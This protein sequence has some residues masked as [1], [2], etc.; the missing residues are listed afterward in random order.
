[1]LVAFLLHF[2]GVI[3]PANS[4]QLG[5]AFYQITYGQEEAICQNLL[6]KLNKTKEIPVCDAINFDLQDTTAPQWE[7]LDI[8]KSL[9]LV[10]LIESD[11]NYEFFKKNNIHR[12]SPDDDDIWLNQLKKR[13]NS[14][15]NPPKLYR[16][17]I[18]LT[19]KNE[20]KWL[21]AYKMDHKKCNPAK[22]ASWAKKNDGMDF[23][24]NAKYGSYEYV[25]GRGRIIFIKDDPYIVDSYLTS[26]THY[27]EWVMT[28]YKITDGPPGS[29]L[30]CY[31]AA[32]KT[33]S[34]PPGQR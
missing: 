12:Y 18:G 32:N 33:F 31:I 3:N 10:K 23:Y 20:I 5:D 26:R 11:E 17:N 8:L 22:F 7:E 28:I 2:Y 1:M 4:Q 15:T 14:S 27:W 19:S 13:V 16:T 24:R 29:G 25:G 21:Y 6:S 9:R 34:H 30:L